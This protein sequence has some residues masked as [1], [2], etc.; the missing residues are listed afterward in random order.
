MAEVSVKLTALP[1]D[2]GQLLGDR[3]KCN[4]ILLATEL[5]ELH[6]ELA[7]L[8][9]VARERLE[10]AREPELEADPDEPLRRVVLV[11]LDRIA[12]IHRELVV[13]VVVALAD[14]HE[15]G[16]EVVLRRV[17]VVERR[18]AEPVRER[19]DTERGLKTRRVNKVCGA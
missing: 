4:T 9:L 17:L 1:R 19:V 11:P 2:D 7:L 8:D 10:L 6:R 12:V 13:E 18:L 3:R 5:L 16:D 15:R 14:G